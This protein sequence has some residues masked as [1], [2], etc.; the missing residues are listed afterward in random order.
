VSETAWQADGGLMVQLYPDPDALAAAAAGWLAERLCAAADE[1]GAVVLAV[2]G[3]TS[4]WP[5]YRR[6]AAEPDVPWET[7]HVVQVDER[8]A[9]DGDP[10]RNWS[11]VHDVFGGVVPERNLHAMPVTDPNFD[12]AAEAYAELLQRLTG[13][14]GLTIAHLGL[15]G[16]GHTASLFPGDPASTLTDRDVA[17]TAAEH[18]GRRRMTLTL[19]AINAAGHILW[20][21]QG[22]GKLGMVERLVAGDRTIPAGTIRRD[23]AVLMTDCPVAAE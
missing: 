9:P 19:P 16:D 2:S 23:R 10:D 21:V 20:Q 1:D 4:P 13:G 17:V 6:L 12:A 7:V 15:G 11:Q 22:A 14:R 18:A 8:I 5:M 3:G